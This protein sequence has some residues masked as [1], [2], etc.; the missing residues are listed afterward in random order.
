[1]TAGNH[2]SHTFPKARHLCLRREIESLFSAGSRSLSVFPVRAVYRSLP[3]STGPQV[4]VL[5]SVS[6]RK[7]RHAVDRN[8][9]KRQLREAYRLNQHLLTG[10]LPE[11]QSLCIGLLWLAA[12]PR[13][14]AAV[15]TA[16]THLLQTIGERLASPAPSHREP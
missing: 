6:K 11:G 8:R 9:A 2:P 5:V 1:M 3:R 16:V 13:P 7:L 12:G 14:T 10:L 15:A 4:K